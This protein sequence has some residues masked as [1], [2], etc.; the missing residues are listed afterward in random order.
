MPGWMPGSPGKSPTHLKSSG[1]ADR[2]ALCRS[3]P[4]L[5]A[6]GAQLDYPLERD[7]E[8]LAVRF[9]LRWPAAAGARHGSCS[10]PRQGN[11]NQSQAVVATSLRP[12]RRHQARGILRWGNSSPLL[13]NLELQE[14]RPIRS[15]SLATPLG[16]KL[17]LTRSCLF[18]SR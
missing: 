12:H 1:A 10:N 11:A 15:R 17:G 8:H 4:S 5:A 2:C 18:G 3:I 13:G 14:L 9:H 16:R 6:L 7:I